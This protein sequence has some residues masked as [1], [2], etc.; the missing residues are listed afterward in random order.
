ML[1]PYAEGVSPI[2]VDG[3]H[4]YVLSRRAMNA[5]VDFAAEREVRRCRLNTSG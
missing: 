5:V 3:G 4:G 2:G 1:R